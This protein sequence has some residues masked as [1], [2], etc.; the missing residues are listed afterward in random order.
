MLFLTILIAISFVSVLGSNQGTLFKIKE[1]KDKLDDELKKTGQDALYISELEREIGRSECGYKGK[2]T[3]K[4]YRALFIEN[5]KKRLDLTQKGQKYHV[6]MSVG[7]PKDAVHYYASK[8]GT[9]I[10][11]IHQLNLYETAEVKVTT[12]IFRSKPEY[13]VLAYRGVSGADRNCL[14]HFI[15][16]LNDGKRF[17]VEKRVLIEQKKQIIAQAVNYFIHTYGVKAEA[18]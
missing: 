4:Y 16:Q 1:T 10:L 15:Q 9:I 5:A 12:G 8:L 13:K 3:E 2:S 7:L 6:E 14:D 17:I 18:Q 11:Q